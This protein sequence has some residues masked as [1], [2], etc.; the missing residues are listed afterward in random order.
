MLGSLPE[1]GQENRIEKT[2]RKNK[3]LREEAEV[4]IIVTHE[5]HHLKA[6]R[7]R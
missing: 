4:E 7:Q 2:D 3:N 6:K 1:V 5:S